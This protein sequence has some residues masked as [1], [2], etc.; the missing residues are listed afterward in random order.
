MGLHSLAFSPGGRYLAAA[1]LDNVVRVYVMQADELLALAEKGVRRGWTKD[2]CK[3]FL[4]GKSCPRS[5]Y[6]ARDEANELFAK[7]DFEGG[8]RLLEEAKGSG[9]VDTD[10]LAAEVAARLGARSFGQP[11]RCSKTPSFGQGGG[12]R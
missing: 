8:R 5:R 7:F 6:N 1:G 3:Q 11:A 10:L 2:E 4:Q 12:G 9:S